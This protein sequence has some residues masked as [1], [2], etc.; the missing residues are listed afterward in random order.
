MRD[1]GIS[2]EELTPRLFS[3]NN[4]YGALPGMH[5]SGMKLELG[6]PADH[7]QSESV[8]QRRA[9][10]ASGWNSLDDGSI[11]RMY[12]NALSEKYGFSLDTPV[13]DLPKSAL[14]AI[15]YGTKGKNWSCTGSVPAATA[16]IPSL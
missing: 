3:F 9:I 2:I 12:F 5:R 16:T 1:C 6:P 14:D 15:L 8:H 13:K 4:P 7:S 11:A 10:K